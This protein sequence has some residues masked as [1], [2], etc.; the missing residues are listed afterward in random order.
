MATEYATLVFK[1]DTKEIGQAFNQLKKLNQQGKIT[2]KTLKSFEKS[3]KGIRGSA[4]QAG[5]AFG[6]MGR[7]AGQA[8][9]QVQQ[10]VGQV[11]AGTDP[12]IALSQ[13]AA[14]LGIVLGLPLVGAILGIS[15]SLV[16]TLLPSLLLASKSFS[17]LQSEIEDVGLEITDLPAEIIAAEMSRLK[18][19]T[20]E[21]TEAFND[22][23]RALNKAK[24]RLEEE[25]AVLERNGVSTENITRQMLGFQTAV[26]S[27]A[28]KVPNLTA[29][30]II[31]TQRQK[32]FELA[33]RGVSEAQLKALQT[34]AE[35]INSLQLEIGAIGL[36][37]AQLTL[38]EA[39]LLGLDEA[40]MKVVQSLVEMREKQQEVEKS[41][42]A[43]DAFLKK[44][45][46][47][48]SATNLSRSETLLLESATLSLTTA[49]QERVAV[50]IDQIEKEEQRTEKMKEAQAA[51]KELQ[52]MGLLDVEG[53]EIDS[54]V[55]REQKLNE[56]RAKQL[57]SE[58][59]FAEASKNLERERN[60]FAIKSAGD[61]LNALGQSNK[62]AFK[63]A[64]AY[65]I[66]Q[67]IMN[68]YTGATKALA[69]LPP[70][71][72]FIVAAA[73]VANGLA[74]VQQIRSQQYQ[75]R[76]LGG[77]VRSGE[78]YVVGERGPEVLTMGSGGRI[79]PNEGMG[80]QAQT[81]NRV[82]NVT[83]QISTVDARGFDSLLQS[84]RG[85]IVNMVNSAMNDQG[86]R[87]VV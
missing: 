48:A 54:F 37:A 51:Q 77:Q 8:G 3:M 66:G 86:R 57:I 71:L 59:Q 38:R 75:G 32:N 65:N 10:L 33:T 60:E 5:T 24:K 43:T 58:R 53:D 84:R 22:N 30:V 13:Q 70:P 67:A 63:L 34:Q 27:A 35:F 85:Q 74:Q 29:A 61:A 31:A 72:N 12:F 11:Q 46:Q 79:T 68:T 40:Q 15:A 42:K 62:T 49:E 73:T 83:F 36:S 19:A 17:D 55:R 20:D 9:I 80:G 44:L 52:R 14:D 87:G 4:G 45:E 18:E 7:S 41:D 47:Q 76:A 78:S 82:A 26:D 1:A 2:D 56:F 64:K 23:E 81:V 25:R 50:L 39:T 21:A 6:G 69:E 28:E 16:G